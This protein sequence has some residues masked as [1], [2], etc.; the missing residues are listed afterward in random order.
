MASKVGK[1]VPPPG[2]QSLFGDKEG[3]RRL[4]LLVSDFAV[5]SRNPLPLLPRHKLDY[6]SQRPL[7]LAGTM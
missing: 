3:V 2:A 7:Q 4:E 1:H 6:I 5:Y